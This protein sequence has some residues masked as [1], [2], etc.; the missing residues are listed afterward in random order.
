M[1]TIHSAKPKHARTNTHPPCACT[2]CWPIARN[3]VIT[4]QP[5]LGFAAT[6][7]KPIELRITL[8]NEHQA[9][10]EL[11]DPANDRS[12]PIELGNPSITTI[13]AKPYTHIEITDGQNTVLS[14][15][16]KAETNNNRLLYARTSLLTKLNIK[17]GRYPAPTSTI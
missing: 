10:A 14:A 1:S 17:G 15:T 5:T 13:D 12:H 7:S 4:A 2:I 8:K 9:A 11:V 6:S 3:A 16:L